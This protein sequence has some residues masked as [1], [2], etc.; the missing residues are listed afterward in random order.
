M[1]EHVFPEKAVTMKEW[2]AHV[3]E[4]NRFLKNFPAHNGNVTQPLDMDRLLDIL[5]FGVPAS[6]RR[7]F[8]V[9]GFGPMDRACT[10][11]WSSVPV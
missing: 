7:E 8:T 2:V 10:N 3:Q 5:Y 1:A 6:W 9:Q 4:L 11:L